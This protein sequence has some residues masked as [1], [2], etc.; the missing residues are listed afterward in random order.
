MIAKH[1][2]AFKGATVIWLTP[3]EILNS[4]GAFDL[5][6]CAAPSPRPWNTASRHIELP[7]NGLQSAWS[8]RVW[9]NPPY[10]E[11]TG[12]WLSRMADHRSG[13]ALIF[14][15]TDT[16]NWQDFIFPIAHSILY[17]R[18]RVRFRYPDG[19]IPKSKT[20]DG[21]SGAPSALISYSEF[22]TNILKLS[23]LRGS[24]CTR[25]SL[26]QQTAFGSCRTIHKA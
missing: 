11:S 7:E 25:L 1:E 20:G 3:P 4:L 16:A 2:R 10:D 6:P 21:R 9:L 18:G 12:D 5:D 13:I 24:L 19:S 15:R 26:F 17:L 14:A 22:D 23:G 8:G